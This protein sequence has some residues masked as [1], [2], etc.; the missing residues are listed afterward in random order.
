[1]TVE[2]PEFSRPVSIHDL[3]EDERT[4][5]IAATPEERQALARRFSLV[6]LDRL[7]AT[8]RLRRRGDGRA[9]LVS[10]LLSADLT[11]TCVVT[12]KPVP[13]HVEEPFSVVFLRDSQGEAAD[14]DLVADELEEVEPLTGDVIDIGE[15]VAQSLFLSLDPYPRLA[16]AR[17]VVPG[18]DGTASAG[19]HAF[20][21]LAQWRK[22]R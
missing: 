3:D 20:S 6:A 21:A 10:G 5:D 12:L 13:A 14:L 19:D 4:E 1:M 22:R 9:V 18:E 8:A 2:T 7:S 16:G 15:L 17:Y 11:Q